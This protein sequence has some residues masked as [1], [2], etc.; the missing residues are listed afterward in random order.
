MSSFFYLTLSILF[1]SVVALTMKAANAG[2]VPF[3][4]LLGINYLVCTI[5]LLAWGGAQTL[6]SNTPL[7]WGLSVFI[8]T[9]FVFCLWLFN[10]AISAQGLALST[11]LMRLSAV[12]PT[13]GSLFFFSEATTFCQLIGIGLAFLSLPLAGREPI[14]F[15]MAG[16][17]AFRGIMWGLF[18]FVAYGITD[19]M[20]KVQAEFV[21]S[22]DPKAFM[23]GIF[24]TA[25][26]LTLP[27]LKNGRPP[28]ISGLLWGVI[29]GFS[30]LLATYFWI[31]TLQN[32]PGSVAYPTLGIGII[33]TT[34]LVSQMLWK[35]KLRPANYL[36][37][38]L[39]CVAVV[40][41]NSG[42]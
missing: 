28:L 1:S 23:S 33:L 18:L 10:K 36:F 30:N 17:K 34:T 12:I 4:P 42:G 19:F 35:E 14:Q 3:W 2:K 29:L 11:T 32:I 39:A 31:R 5:C 27:C 41:I 9:M 25:L 22:V 26:I 16:K 38:I 15:N 7:T 20:F 37:L 21:P 13:L 40:F 8:G 24:A 6:E